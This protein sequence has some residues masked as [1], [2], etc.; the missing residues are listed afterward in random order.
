MTDEI[1]KCCE[2]CPRAEYEIE[3]RIDGSTY[4]KNIICTIAPT[5]LKVA[6]TVAFQRVSMMCPLLTDA[7]NPVVAE[8]TY[9][10]VRKL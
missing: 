6:Y 5:R 10:D 7:T 9:K 1:P 4:I 2:E 8:L 3:E